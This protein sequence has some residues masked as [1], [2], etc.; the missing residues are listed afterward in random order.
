MTAIRVDRYPTARSGGEPGRAG[1]R[2]RDA[3]GRRA[4]PRQRSGDLVP[5]ELSGPA[6]LL[7]ERAAAAAAA[8]YARRLEGELA[9]RDAQIARMADLLR[10]IENGRLMR[11][12]RALRRG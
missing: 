3:P 8:G 2:G 4:E 11:I 10:R 5:A 9:A 6:R 1:R 12:L 7:A